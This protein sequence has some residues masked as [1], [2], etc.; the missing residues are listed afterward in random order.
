MENDTLEQNLE[1]VVNTLE[2]VLEM[3][4]IQDFERRRI[5]ESI[6]LLKKWF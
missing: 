2:C 4:Y 3:N 1:I 5:E 6:R